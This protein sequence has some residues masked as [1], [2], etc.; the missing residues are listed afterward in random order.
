MRNTFGFCWDNEGRLLGAENGPDA[1]APEELNVIEQG[2][3]Y[4]FPFVFAD[5][6]EN[7]YPHTPNAPPGPTF[8]APLRNLG[9]DAGGSENGIATFDPHSCP[10]GIVYLWRD[11]P[12]PLGGT[13]L[14]A[15]FGNF[16]KGADVGFDVVQFAPD[17]AASTT[18]AKRLA[19]ALGRPIDLLKLSGHRLVI[20]EH[21][22]ATTRAAGTGTPG[23]LLLLAPKSSVPAPPPDT[24]TSKPCR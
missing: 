5:W 22:R 24:A 11:W 9:P 1:D 20:A 2:R 12:T 7:A 6:K 23:R 4:G 14:T 17:F 16:L 15:R 19:G 18:T 8:T 13:F 3:H 10:T 21:C